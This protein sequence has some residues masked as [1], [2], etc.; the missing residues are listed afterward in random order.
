MSCYRLVFVNN[1][2]VSCT[3]TDQH[4]HLKNAYYAQRDGSMIFAVVQAED[5]EH[6]L[7]MAADLVKEIKGESR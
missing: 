3:E 4:P 1:E 6:A 2:V 7:Q 5:D